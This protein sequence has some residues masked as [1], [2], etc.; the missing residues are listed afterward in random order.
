MG[1]EIRVMFPHGLLGIIVNYQKLER[2]NEKIL[3]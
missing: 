1:A 3:P 2:G